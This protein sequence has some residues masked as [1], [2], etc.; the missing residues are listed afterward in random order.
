MQRGVVTDPLHLQHAAAPAHVGMNQVHRLVVYQ[1][2]EAFRQAVYRLTHQNGRGGGLG[3]FLVALPFE[4]PD[5]A[6]MM[7]ELTAGYLSGAEGTIT[8]HDAF[9]EVA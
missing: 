4:V 2:L 5:E 6:F 8:Y 9:G 3:D 7:L 1:V